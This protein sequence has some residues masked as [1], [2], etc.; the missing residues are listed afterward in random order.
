M[1]SPDLVFNPFDR[2]HYRDPYP[3]YKRLREEAPVYRNETLGLVALSR[4]D[5]RGRR[6]YRRRPLQL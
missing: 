4:F 3:T 1:A 5:E 6:P 2:E